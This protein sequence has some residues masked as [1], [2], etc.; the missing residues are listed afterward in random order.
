MVSIFTNP[1]ENRLRAGWR[2]FLFLIIGFFALATISGI[3]PFG[4]WGFF[5]SSVVSTLL[6][7]LFGTYIDRRHFAGFGLNLSPLWWREL[8]LGTAIGAAAIAIVFAIAT[9]FGWFQI[10][11]YGW[12]LEGFLYA[13]GGYLMMMIFV[14][15]YEELLF[16]GYMNLNLFEG[17][18]KGRFS[19]SWIPGLASIVAISALFAVAH[20]NNPN[21]TTFGII[22]V[23]LAGIILG[24]P[25]LATG[26][27]ALSIGIHFAWN[28]VQG[29]IFGIPVSGIPFRHSLLRIKSEGDPFITGGAFGF[30]GGVLGLLGI[31]IVCLLGGWYLWKKAY[32]KRVHPRIVGQ[33]SQL[34]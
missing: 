11:G 7:W 23:L 13:F 1:T 15:Y 19:S 22:N 25:F 8:M 4:A 18:Y 28:F 21:A 6:V 31:L 33:T 20:A 30:E 14:G 27:L 9:G 24:I 12:Q 17:F 32:V 34:G 5:A 10:I 26:R 29:G 16:R 2:I 3:F